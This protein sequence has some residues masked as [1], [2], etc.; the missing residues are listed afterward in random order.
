MD[1]S[2]YMLML[3]ALGQPLY[4][5]VEL[6][7]ISERTP[8][9]TEMVL[10]HICHTTLIFA[11]L[12]SNLYHYGALILILHSGSDIFL[13]AIKIM[14]LLGHMNVIF[15]LLFTF[16]HVAWIF[17]RLICLPALIYA[18]HSGNTFPDEISDLKV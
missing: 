7:F 5:S 18:M 3:I 15:Y 16:T 1:S 13:Q 9:F 4:N 11:C 12:T 10:H 8:D 6:L 14:M 17:F 2:T